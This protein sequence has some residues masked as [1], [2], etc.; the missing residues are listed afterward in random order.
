MIIDKECLKRI[1][2]VI[3]RNH[4]ARNSDR[5]KSIDAFAVVSVIKNSTGSVSNDE[6][7]IT[8]E[9]FKRF[10]AEAQQE[11]VT[12]AQVMKLIQVS[13]FN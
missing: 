6:K 10:L 13:H 5:G 2:D 3:T 4:I 7:V 8:F 11:D 9:K 1:S 12:D